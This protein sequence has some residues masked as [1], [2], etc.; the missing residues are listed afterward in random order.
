M[1][2]GGSCIVPDIEEHN[3][4][5]RLVARRVG[6]EA[7]HVR[8][9][10][11]VQLAREPHVV[12]GAEWPAAQF[13][14]PDTGGA[15]DHVPKVHG[16]RVTEAHDHLLRRAAAAHALHRRIERRVERRACAHAFRTVLEEARALETALRRRGP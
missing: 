5:S 15:A 1:R 12:G 6:T 9:C 4:P 13:V 10:Q 14:K 2:G 3:E 11:G 16:A 8:E 7:R